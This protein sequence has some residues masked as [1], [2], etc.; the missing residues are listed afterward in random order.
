M[1]RDLEAGH[2]GRRGTPQIM[3]DP[4]RDFDRQRL[5]GWRTHRTPI[6][7]IALWQIEP[8]PTSLFHLLV[9]ASLGTR[10]PRHRS[11]AGRGEAQAAVD[12][13]QGPQDSKRS[14]RQRHEV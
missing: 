12:A 14:G 8:G 7:G 9:Q 3:D 10:E 13:G 11:L 4:W 2:A 6:F 5:F 1:W